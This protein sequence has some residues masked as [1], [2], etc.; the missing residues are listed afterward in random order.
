MKSEKD[1]SIKKFQQIGLRRLHECRN[2]ISAL[3]LKVSDL[4]NW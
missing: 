4:L 1:F 2:A 3:M